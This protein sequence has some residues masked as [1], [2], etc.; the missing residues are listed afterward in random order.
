MNATNMS[1]QSI[2]LSN[3][4]VNN[5]IIAI[6]IFLLGLIIGRI[7]GKLVEKILKDFRVDGTVRKTTGLKTS[8]ER[9]A[10]SIISYGIYFIFFIIALNY[11]GITSLLLNILSIA[12]I[13]ILAISLILTIRDNIPN[14]IAYNALRKNKGLKIG[15]Y[16]TIKAVKGTVENMSLF[17]VVI[18][19]DKED[20][21]H[22]PNSLFLQEQFTCKARKKKPSEAKGPRKVVKS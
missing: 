4:L 16:I 2:L 11:V 3:P 13:L 15:D 22:I 9:I 14:I 6:A 21:I 18:K 1:S 7:L 20:R 17:E 8:L 19:T 12:I 5:I 10:G